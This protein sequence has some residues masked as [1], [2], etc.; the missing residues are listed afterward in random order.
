M[1]VSLDELG[2]YASFLLAEV[3]SG[4]SREDIL[5]QSL[6]QTEELLDLEA[7][8]PR[9][10]V[11]RGEPRKDD[12]LWVGWIHYELA[13]RPS[14]YL[15]NDNEVLDR[16]HHL[17]LLCRR[18]RHLAIFASEATA[19]ERIRRALA[20]GTLEGLSGLEPMPFDLLNAAFV[21]D[22]P[23]RTLWLSG[24]HRSTPTKADSKILAGSDLRD[25]LNPLADQSYYFTAARCV[26]ELPNLPQRESAV[27]IGVSP[28][29]S[30]VWAGPVRAWE[31]LRDRT[32]ALLGQLKSHDLA[33]ASE[34]QPLPVLAS[35]TADAAT[36]AD[37]Y[38]ITVIDPALLADDGTLDDDAR[39]LAERWAYRSR[40]VIGPA[41]GSS[42]EATIELD[43]REIG[44]FEFAIN[45]R[46]D[47]VAD[48]EVVPATGTDPDDED[49]REALS[50]F[51]ERYWL[52][53]FYD[54]GHT[55]ASGR[56][57]SMRYRDVEFDNWSFQSIASEGFDVG[58]EKP[59][60][61]SSFEVDDIGVDGEASLFSWTQRNW[62]PA[63][64]DQVGGQPQRG[65][66]CSDDGSGEIADFI[67][68]DPALRDGRGL[69][70]LIHVKASGTDT[71]TRSIS[72]SDYE[73]VVGQAVKNLRSLDRRTL[74][75]GLEDGAGKQVASAV[76]V[77]GDKRQ[78]RTEMIQALKDHGD[79]YERL[80]VI[81]QPR[82]R[83]ASYEEVRE[84]L[85]EIRASNAAETAT[86]LRMR[87]LDT[88]LEGAR[89]DCR[90]LGADLLVISDD[91]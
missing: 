22:G 80:V 44:N 42:F 58:K 12:V 79:S 33:D 66:L 63:D 85:G 88:L 70:T 74:V 73:V 69:V 72:N 14:W 59:G 26:T 15:S 9:T 7:E 24:I 75:G 27:A 87:Q 29:K 36:V 25:A 52:K 31:E 32:Y 34:F 51:A 38:D 60:S 40:C 64:I 56:M 23:A 16:I 13:H 78:D 68:F 49:V 55:L 81:L 86:T 47:G 28:R 45:V 11:S 61:G 71:A 18:D 4:A 21:A 67:H 30:R 39:A 57:F 50:V 20:G 10:L 54:S 91:A 17:V 89:A 46:E 62:P 43:D 82:V 83:S 35:P 48:V 76:W 19:R 77:D 65:F 1:P 37:P 5:A 8:D 6:D 3:R 84:A 2:P 90:A 41:T 53:V